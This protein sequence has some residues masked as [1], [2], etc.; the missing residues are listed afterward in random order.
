MITRNS[1]AAEKVLLLKLLLM[2]LLFS[3]THDDNEIALKKGTIYINGIV[4][5]HEGNSGV[6][7]LIV[8][9][10]LYDQ[11]NSIVLD[12]EGNFS[13]ELELLHPQDVKLKYEKGNVQLFVRQGDSLF[14]SLD[15]EKCKNEFFPSFELS[16][17]NP[18]PSQQIWHYRQYRKL[19]MPYP[20]PS[21][22]TVSAFLGELEKMVHIEDSLLTAYIETY[23]PGNDFVVWARSF[24]RYQ[25][26][27]FLIDYSASHR[28][29]DFSERQQLFANTLFPVNND[30]ALF[31]SD[32]SMHLRHYF[33]HMFLNEPAVK[34]LSKDG[35]ETAAFQ[36]ALSKSLET[37]DKGISRDIMLFATLRTLSDYN[38]DAFRSLKPVFCD[39]I[40]SPHL[41]EMLDAINYRST[42]YISS[43]PN[44][45]LLDHIFESHLNQVVYVSFWATWC[46]PCK[47]EIPFVKLLEKEFDGRDVSFVHIC[48]SSNIAAWE[49]LKKD[50][51]GEHHFLE[52]DQG[53][54]LRSI[55]NIKGYPTY[56]LIDRSGQLVYSEA[57]RPSQTAGLIQLIEALLVQ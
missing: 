8:A 48:M 1:T 44:D 57:L 3:C 50:I 33:L 52:K 21:K 2:A 42:H 49:A 19:E 29:M 39:N 15:A 11:Y 54:L 17:N 43:I 14:V 38:M 22:L 40:E 47:A 31:S 9:N 30:N 34:Q 28:N 16:G 45:K 32:F 36:L 12:E 13:F 41:N 53:D 27:N 5:G 51:P 7:S 20:D 26:A 25:Y 37:L 46:G 4:N 24:F 6:I 35:K 55:L 23:K 10:E 18:E 56:M